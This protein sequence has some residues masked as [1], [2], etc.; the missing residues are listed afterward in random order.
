MAMAPMGFLEPLRQLLSHHGDMLQ[1]KMGN[2]DRS[3]AAVRANTEAQ[4]LRKAR[5]R[6]T[7]RTAKEKTEQLRND[8]AYGWLV[9]WVASTDKVSI[10]VGVESEDGFMLHL[11]KLGAE[12]VSWYLPLNGVIFVKNEGAGAASTNFEV[13]VQETFASEGF[14]GP[15][16]EAIEVERREQQPPTAPFAPVGV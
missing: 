12:K 5:V 2:M 4:M 1:D 15:S 6:K 9:E 16:G 3:L 13:E 11:E 7:V 8:S 14:T 10:F